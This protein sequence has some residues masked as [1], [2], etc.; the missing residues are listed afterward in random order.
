[1][2]ESGPQGSSGE[3]PPVQ[4]FREKYAI[5]LSLLVPAL[6]LGLGRGFTAPVIPIIARDDFQVSVGVA[7]LAMIAQMLGL[8]LGTLPTGYIAD[9]WGRRKVLLTAPLLNAASAFAVFF[10]QEYY[11]FMLL[12]LIN[13][14]SLQMW[15]LGR[16]SVIADT[17]RAGVRGRQITSMSALQRIGTLMGPLLGGIVG[18]F[19]GLRI[20]FI[21]YGFL[22]LLAFIP[23]ALFIKETSPSLLARQR[24][25]TYKREANESWRALLQFPVL[26]LF[27][28]QFM[29]NIARGGTVGNANPFFLFAAFAFGAGAAELG[30]ISFLAGIVSVPMTL[31]SGFIMDRFGRKRGVV[32]ASTVLGFSLGYMA[33]VAAFDL[34]FVHFVVSF[35]F[36][37]MAVSTMAGSMQTIGSDIAP[38]GARGKFFGVSR[39][40]GE[41][42]SLSNPT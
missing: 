41:M 35:V 34:S 3:E 26:V 6:L 38:V 1:M 24:G 21:L 12:L 23:M 11:Q 13:G 36:I 28:A 9:R 33:A 25:E 40:M 7:G 16:V 42:G 17:G 15:Q 22:A 10:A 19:F 29:V 30:G 14:V 4:S 8:V 32:P 31:L 37:N 27:G 39:L 18:E 2:R 5:W 20:P